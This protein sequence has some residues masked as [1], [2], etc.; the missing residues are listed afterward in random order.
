MAR[1][2]F[3]KEYALTCHWP[4]VDDVRSRT[5]L[6]VILVFARIS[7]QWFLDECIHIYSNNAMSKAARIGRR[8]SSTQE[9]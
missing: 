6:M 8:F 2:P 5:A 1:A 9:L 3:P 7:Y 4:V